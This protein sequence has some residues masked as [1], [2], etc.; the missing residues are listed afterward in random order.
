M[1]TQT[2]KIENS[3]FVNVREALLKYSVCCKSYFV[4]NNY[5]EFHNL[6]LQQ[7]QEFKNWTRSFVFLFLFKFWISKFRKDQIVFRGIFTDD[8]IA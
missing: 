4:N 6:N 8:P 5:R 7:E 2:W 1:V 3:S